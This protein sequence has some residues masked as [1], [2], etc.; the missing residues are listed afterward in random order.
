VGS[1]LASRMKFFRILAPMGDIKDSFMDLIIPNISLGSKL[2]K[3]VVVL[4][5]LKLKCHGLL[6]A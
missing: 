3:I 6:E 5:S 4:F 2:L 1:L